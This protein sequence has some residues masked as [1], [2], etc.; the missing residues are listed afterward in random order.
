MTVNSNLICTIL[1]YIFIILG[2]AG[3][4]VLLITL[5]KVPFSK[6]PLRDNPFLVNFLLTTWLGSLPAP[7]MWAGVILF[8]PPLIFYILRCQAFW[9]SYSDCWRPDTVVH[10]TSCFVGWDDFYVYKIPTTCVSFFSSAATF[11]KV[12]VNVN[13]S[14]VDGFQVS[15]WVPSL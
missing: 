11:C 10:L 4:L 1:S 3:L 15:S 7:L 6:L 12:N 2:N 13:P 8:V 9:W 14:S 5:W